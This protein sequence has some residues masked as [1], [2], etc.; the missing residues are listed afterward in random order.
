[1]HRAHV[2]L[3]TPI[4]G[5][6]RARGP[7]TAE[8]GCS[9]AAAFAEASAHRAA[10]AAAP[11][12]PAF[13]PAGLL[14]LQRAIGNAGVARLLQP[15]PRETPPNGQP[16]RRFGGAE[17]REI[18]EQ[19]S[20]QKYVR[21]GTKGYAL[22][23]GELVA[24][25]GDIF[26]DIAYME[27]LADT[28][29]KG[30]ETQEALDYARYI[31]IGPDDAHG[32][33]PGMRQK[34]DK[35][36]YSPETRKAVDDMYYNLAANNAKHFVAPRGK[37]AASAG[38][39]RPYSGG[40]SY[41]AYHEEALRRAQVAGKAGTPDDAALAAEGFGAH[42]LT[43][44]VSAGHLRTPRLDIVEHWDKANP[45]LVERFKDYLA[46][47]VTEWIV[48]HK[49]YGTTVR[50]RY[51]FKSAMDSIDAALAGRPPL[52]MGVLVSLAL[53]DYDN[54]HGLRVLSGGQA[55]TVYGDGYLHKGNTEE[56]AV[57]AVKAGIDDVKQAYQLGAAGKSFPEIKATLLGGGAL[58]KPESILPR[59]DPMAMRQPMPKWKVGS[60]E[61]LLADPPMREALALAVTNNISE[62]KSVA[63]AQ[64]EPGRTA[65]LEGFVKRVQGDTI[66]ELTA[67]YFNDGEQTERFLST[68]D[69]PEQW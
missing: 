1:M 33:L 23:Y 53:H 41:R 50:P 57:T 26:P 27:K 37:D 20:N 21:L 45:H 18:G 22:G 68:Y 39:D 6:H 43:D 60:F 65:I 64:K 2:D 28:P 38:P 67:I 5:N 51:T 17:H 11:W 29:G 7:R 61:D 69:F 48:A 31:L 14:L 44:A 46:F 15:F 25:A 30:P 8:P 34:Y 3:S 40:E 47:R 36:S 58:Y 54:K 66:G 4:S 16:I 32:G 35:T 12:G 49:W 55:K 19:A 9:G 62:I 56:I 42:F 13:D 59:L 52:T 63:E 10:P 24:L